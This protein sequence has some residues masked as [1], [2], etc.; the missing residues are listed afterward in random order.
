MVVMPDADLDRAIPLV[1]ESFYGCAGERCLAG[2]VLLPVGPVHAE[3]RDRLVEAARALA[4]G[5]GL[6]PATDMGPVISAAHRTRVE[7]YVALGVAEGASLALDGRSRLLPGRGFFV[8]PSVFDRVAPSMRIGREEIF[9][10]V[11]TVCPVRDLD[12]A[13][14]IMDGHPN[15]NATSIFTSSGRAA[16]EF[17]H[18]APASM[19]GINI[20]VAA[21][22][23]YFPFGGARDSFFGDLKVHGRDAFAFYTD[24]KVTMSRWS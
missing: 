4:V 13:L 5:D 18:R 9:G 24:P 11:A 20:G 19:V 3:T 23:A 7:Q 6:D 21:P 12:E 14:A 8:G 15:A 16:R 22:M 17:A 2:S 1:T 10:P